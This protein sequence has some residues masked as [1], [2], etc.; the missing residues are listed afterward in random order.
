MSFDLW[1][2]VEQLKVHVSANFPFCGLCY[3]WPYIATLTHNTPPSTLTHT[4]SPLE[5]FAVKV[6]IQSWVWLWIS[7]EKVKTTQALPSYLSSGQ[8]VADTSSRALLSLPHDCFFFIAVT[9]LQPWIHPAL[10]GRPNVAWFVTVYVPVIWTMLF[11]FAKKMVSLLLHPSLLDSD[12]LSQS[13]FA[14]YR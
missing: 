6:I 11:L 9:I 8:R 1:I 3:W 13:C 12:I 2:S 5:V 14:S 7:V 10:V 4:L